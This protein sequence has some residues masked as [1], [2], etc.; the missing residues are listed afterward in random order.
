MK[1]GDLVRMKREEAE[2]TQYDWAQ[3][4]QRCTMYPGVG[5]VVNIHTGTRVAPI[6]VLWP[7]GEVSRHGKFWMETV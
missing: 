7:N 1:V 2:D 5:V 6:E 3:R 4:R